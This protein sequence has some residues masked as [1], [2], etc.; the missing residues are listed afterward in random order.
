MNS[1]EFRVLSYCP[2]IS[3]TTVLCDCAVILGCK[4][5]DAIEEKILV[6]T[7]SGSP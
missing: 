5:V 7:I 1:Y 3:M 2:L 4:G 6:Q